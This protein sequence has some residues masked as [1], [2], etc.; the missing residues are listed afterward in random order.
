MPIYKVTT[1]LLGT[2]LVEAKTKGDVLETINEEQFISIE[3]YQCKE[4]ESVKKTHLETELAEVL[5]T[6]SIMLWKSEYSRIFRGEY[7]GNVYTAGHIKDVLNSICQKDFE[8]TLVTSEAS[9]L[10]QYLLKNFPG[11]PIVLGLE[12]D[13]FKVVSQGTKVVSE[14]L[15]GAL[16]NLYN[17]LFKEGEKHESV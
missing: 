4:K 7:K 17:V 8:E 3:A 13:Y 11:N 15:R 2:I 9:Y 10:I 1:K 12:D 16:E 6:D 5:K 14:S